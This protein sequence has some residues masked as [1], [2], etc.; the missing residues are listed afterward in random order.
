MALYLD[1]ATSYVTI[2]T[3]VLGNKQVF[4]IELRIIAKDSRTG[5]S[6]WN[7]PTLCGLA[8]D[9]SNSGD[10]GI[11]TKNGILSFWSGLGTETYYDTSDNI[12][13][14]TIHNI[15]LVSDGSKLTLY[16]DGIPYETTIAVSRAIATSNICI[17]NALSSANI[18]TAMSL[19]EARFWSTARTVEELGSTISGT[20]TG[21]QAWYKC[22]DVAAGAT[23]VI[24]YSSNTYHATIVGDV[25][26]KAIITP[27]T[28]VSYTN[29]HDQ[30][31]ITPDTM[32]IYTNRH[33]QQTITP[34]IM[35]S[36]V[37]TAAPDLY[38][39]V[40]PIWV[41]VYPHP[42]TVATPEA[43][44]MQGVSVYPHTGAQKIRLQDCIRIS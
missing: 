23:S 19:Y 31:T 33:D 38:V 26:K 4:T 12:V 1:G 29:R 20:E 9:G 36:Y 13:D 15:A 41:P 28:M 22:E 42:S 7:G 5:G 3:A 16:K 43:Y 34:I 39:G 17:G 18:A 6:Y 21:L 24:D 11:C 8:T 32:V 35:A 2:P 10:F 40:G 37:E 27:D 25:S 30:Q 44:V 14:R